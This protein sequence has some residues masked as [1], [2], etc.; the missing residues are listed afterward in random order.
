MIDW[1]WSSWLLPYGKLSITIFHTYIFWVVS[2]VLDSIHLALVTMMIYYYTISN[3]GDAIALS[4]TTWYCF[5]PEFSLRICGWPT[6][7]TLEVQIVVAVCSHCPDKCHCTLTWCT[8]DSWLWLY[9]ASSPSGSGV[10][11]AMSLWHVDSSIYNT[12][13]IC[14]VSKNRALTGIIVG[15]LKFS[16]FLLLDR[17]YLNQVLLSLMGLGACIPKSLFI[18]VLMNVQCTVGFDI[19]FTV[20]G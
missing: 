20:H 11:S 8:R 15:P 1:P 2:R 3:W 4:R 18:I 17:W 7:R 14:L 5:V 9:S 19:A 13:V 16:Y 6:F 10:V 12:A